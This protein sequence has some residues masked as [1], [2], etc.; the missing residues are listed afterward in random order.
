MLDEAGWAMGADGIRA[1]DGQ[2][3]DADRTIGFAVFRALYEAAQSN[4]APD[5]RGPR[6]SRS[7]M[8]RPPTEAN[9]RGD[10][11]WP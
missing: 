1:K 6:R 8:P 9:Q 4:A 2:P 5:R 7:S 3:L 11:H 10:H